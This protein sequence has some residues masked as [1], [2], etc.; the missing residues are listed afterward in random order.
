MEHAID[1]TVRLYEPLF[2]SAEPGKEG[3]FRHDLHPNS[4]SIIEAKGE[5]SLANASVGDQFQFERQGFFV[6]DPDTQRSGHLIVNR[7]VALK[8]SWTKANVATE[9]TNSPALQTEAPRDPQ[10]TKRMLGAI[11]EALMGVGLSEDEA[12]VLESDEVLR[13]W[14]DTAL[15]SSKSAPRAVAGFVVTELPK[16]ARAHSGLSALPFD[17][18]ALGRL[19][20]LVE[21]SVITGASAKIVLEAMASGEGSPDEIVRARDLGILNDRIQIERLIDEVLD[22]HPDQV[23]AYGKGRLGLMGFFVGNIVQCTKGRAD[24]SLVRAILDEKLARP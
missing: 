13:G 5:P 4:L 24:P 11:G 22:A 2:L 14:Y 7:S 12:S 6:V 15:E 10:K 20:A 18:V 8:D 17:A 21:S 1:L 9:A 16:L 19:A 23:A 3:D